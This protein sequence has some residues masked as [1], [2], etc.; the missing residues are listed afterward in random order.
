MKF[1]AVLM[2]VCILFL[3]TTGMTKPAEQLPVKQICCSKMAGMHPGAMKKMQEK[4]QQGCDKQGCTMM[5]SC[6]LCGF[7]IIQP[8][9]VQPYFIIYYEKPN[10]F[11]RIGDPSAYHVSSWK[12]PKVC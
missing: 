11:Y 12:P 9:R 7:I 6:T 4:H 10:S 5:F 8:L 1:L 3:S 2:S